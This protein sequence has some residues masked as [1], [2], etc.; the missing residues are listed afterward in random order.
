MSGDSISMGPPSLMTQSGADFDQTDSFIPDESFPS[1]E[2]EHQNHA[3]GVLSVS[4]ILHP[5]DCVAQL[6]LSTMCSPQGPDILMSTQI[7]MNPP[8]SDDSL[9][10][11]VGPLAE[12]ENSMKTSS[13]NNNDPYPELQSSLV[14]K[15]D[16]LDKKTKTS[17]AAVTTKAIDNVST[18]TEPHKCQKCEELH[19]YHN[20]KLLEMANEIQ[21]QFATHQQFTDDYNKASE[22]A[23]K[24]IKDLKDQLE[25]AD[26]HL[27]V[28]FTVNIEMEIGLS[29]Y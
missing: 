4:S 10:I 28:L 15:I 12:Y 17:P 21:H 3:M 2:K 19:L 24:Q 23:Q 14:Q 1:T 29:F 11:D 9:T 25:A 22:N 16:Q 26:K 5:D 13:T 20:K 6:L 7:N 18:Q 8:E 27:K